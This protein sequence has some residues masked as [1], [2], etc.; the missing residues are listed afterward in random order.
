MLNLISEYEIC[1][2]ISNLLFF[3]K[4]AFTYFKQI[5]EKELKNQVTKSNKMYEKIPPNTHLRD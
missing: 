4:S 3:S 1:K 2:T 5:E